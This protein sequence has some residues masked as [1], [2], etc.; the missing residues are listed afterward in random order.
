VRVQ[1]HDKKN[2]KL[3]VAVSERVDKDAAN[4]DLT[5]EQVI[6]SPNHD[7]LTLSDVCVCRH[8]L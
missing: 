4:Q 5:P 1:N 6:L 3:K 7:G 8:S 2:E